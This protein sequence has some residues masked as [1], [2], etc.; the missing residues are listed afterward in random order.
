M[1]S[2]TSNLWTPH[3]HRDPLGKQLG[4]LMLLCGNSP[5]PRV[6]Q[7]SVKI[8]WHHCLSVCVGVIKDQ[9]LSD[10]TLLGVNVTDVQRQNRE[11]FF[12]HQD[13]KRSTC[14]SQLIWVTRRLCIRSS[15]TLVRCVLCRCD[16]R[17]KSS[18]VVLEVFDV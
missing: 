11:S 2:S 12:L 8:R 4:N 14:C 3:Q 9:L 16:V 13:V 18:I 15:G 10:A 5:E 1:P 7:H 17:V 6:L